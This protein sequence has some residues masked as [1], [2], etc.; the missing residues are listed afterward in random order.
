VLPGIT[1]FWQVSGRANLSFDQMIELDLAYVRQVSVLTDLG[2]M[3][4]TFRAVLK[5]QGAY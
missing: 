3:A 5:G 2:V 1:R 4:R